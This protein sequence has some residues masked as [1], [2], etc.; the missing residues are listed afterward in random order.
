MSLSAIKCRWLAVSGVAVIMTTSTIAQTTENTP[1]QVEWNLAEIYESLDA[2]QREKNELDGRVAELEGFK[3]R[4]GDSAEALADEEVA[5]QAAEREAE[6]QGS[7][8]D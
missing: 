6:E 2:W 8:C 5:E 3:G 1:R 7:F 4:L